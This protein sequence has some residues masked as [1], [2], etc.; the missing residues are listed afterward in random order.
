MN[1][2]NKEYFFENKPVS[3]EEFEKLK[4]RLGSYQNLQET[5]ERFKKFKLQF[6]Q[7]FIHGLQN[8]NVIGDYLINC[9]NSEFCFDSANLWDCK[10]VFQAFDKLNNAMDIQECGE[11]EKIYECAFSGYNSQNLLFT[12]HSLG[13]PADLLYCYYCPHSKNLF[14][15]VS[16]QHKEYCILNKQYTKEEY[17]TLVPRIIEHMRKTVEWGEF[18]PIELSSFAYNE[19]LADQYYPLTQVEVKKNGWKWKNPEET[20][21]KYFSSEVSIPDYIEQVDETICAKILACEVSKKNYKIIP[22]ELKLLKQIKMPI[23]RR[24]FFQRLIDNMSLRNARKLYSRNCSRCEAPIQT[25]YSPDGPEIVYCEE[26]YLKA[27]Y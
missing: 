20:K 24:C 4:Q 7:K 1:L 16:V 26:C 9:K 5:K 14:G 3:K 23:P 11:A 12:T 6:P 13:E 21:S 10:Y 25:T 17:E 19:T 18:F 22:Q 2:R 8:E 15:C 27:M